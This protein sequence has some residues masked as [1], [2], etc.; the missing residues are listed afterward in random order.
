MAITANDFS[1]AA[2]TR[3]LSSGNPIQEVHPGA[4]SQKKVALQEQP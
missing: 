3:A 4:L 2:K 1:M